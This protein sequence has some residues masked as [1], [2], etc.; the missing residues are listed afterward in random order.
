VDFYSVSKL[1]HVVCA[2]AWVGGGMTLLAN[3]IFT[4]AAKGETE[5]LRTLDIMNGLAKSW[6]IPASMLT[7]V[8][9]AITTTF[10]GMWTEPWVLLGLAGFASTFVTG[11]TVFEPIGKQIEELV[12]ANQMDAALAKG[13]TLLRIA[14]FD[15]T[16][17]LVVIAD[18]VLKP[19]WSDLITLG[20]FAAILAVGAFFFLAGGKLGIAGRARSVQ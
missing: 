1:L 3:S 19:Y 10:G 2:I 4:I 20:L 18:M 9:G 5:V 15:Y 7:L 13:R 6:F 14:K 16:V 8:F 11:L 17:M 12:A